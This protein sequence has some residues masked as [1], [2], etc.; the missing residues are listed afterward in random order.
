MA[1]TEDKSLERQV[2]EKLF[3]V[4]VRAAIVV[5]ATALAVKAQL[6]PEYVASLKDSI[7]IFADAAAQ[8]VVAIA[9]I[10]LTIGWSAWEKIT[11]VKKVET[12]KKENAVLTDV[13]IEKDAQLAES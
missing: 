7:G 9:T 2:A 12:L 3:G 1:S 11:T 4:S 5:G 13:I 6:S 8:L 10:V